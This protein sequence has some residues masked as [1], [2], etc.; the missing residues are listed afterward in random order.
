MKKNRILTLVFLAL[1]VAA[2]IL[3]ACGPKGT[4]EPV[5][6]TVT[7][8]VTTEL[9]LSDSALHKMIVVT[10][11]LT[12][13]KKGAADYTGVRMSDLLAKAGVQS[14]AATV[15]LTGSD[16]FTTDLALAD[17][18]ACTDCLVTFDATASVYDAAM[19][20]MSGKAWVNGLV[21]IEIK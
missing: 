8:K 1:A 11:N 3:S 4:P 10:L 12:H 9:Q 5:T 13:P 17:V 20:G 14:G 6:L 18:Q 2:L 21:T 19:P 7:G 16:G 15:T